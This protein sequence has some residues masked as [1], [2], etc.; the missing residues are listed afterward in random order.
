MMQGYEEEN[1]ANY[2]KH[3]PILQKISIGQILYD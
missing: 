3:D 1:D 2:L